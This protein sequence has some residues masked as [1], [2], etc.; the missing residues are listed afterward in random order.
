MSVMSLAVASVN[1]LH[2]IAAQQTY[3]VNECMIQAA[4]CSPSCCTQVH[5]TAAWIVPSACPK[6]SMAGLMFL[7]E[8]GGRKGEREGERMCYVC[9]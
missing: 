4:F 8:R 9:I 2:I 3:V 6:L 1:G 5:S 7:G